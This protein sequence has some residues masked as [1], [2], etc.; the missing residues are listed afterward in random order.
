MAITLTD[1]D[2]VRARVLCTCQT[3][4]GINIL[5]FRV[6]NSQGAGATDVQAALKLD[7]TL[8]P[9]YKPLI[10]A[11]AVY[12]GVGLSIPSRIPATQETISVANGGAGTGGAVPCPGN[13][14]GL[15]T[16]KTANA[17]RKYRGRSYIP[18]PSVSEVASN[19]SVVPTYSTKLTN[20]ING[21][22]VLITVGTAPNTCQLNLQVV[23]AALTRQTDVILGVGSTDFWSQRRREYGRR[24][25]L[26]IF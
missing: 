13:V 25:D 5:H 3:Q 9:L 4:N 10:S 20:L 21:L 14:T 2:I 18:F 7:Q 24:P 17:G 23:D 22:T 12:V 6:L 11:A 19:G 16:W 26:P 8:A 1:G 15:I